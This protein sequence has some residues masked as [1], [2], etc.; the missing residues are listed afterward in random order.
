MDI[1]YSVCLS[2]NLLFPKG[3][4]QIHLFQFCIEEAKV[5][6]FS[7][8][9]VGVFVLLFPYFLFTIKGDGEKIIAII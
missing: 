8:G 3:L 1:Q 7:F 9:S 2:S 6:T 4:N 5:R